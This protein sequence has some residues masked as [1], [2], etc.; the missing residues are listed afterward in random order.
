MRALFDY[1]VITSNRISSSLSSM[2]RT[3]SARAIQGGGNGSGFETPRAILRTEAK[4]FKQISKQI[5]HQ[6]SRKHSEML[7]T[8]NNGAKMNYEGKLIK[9]WMNELTERVFVLN[10]RKRESSGNTRTGEEKRSSDAGEEQE[11]TRGLVHCNMVL[12]NQGS[13]IN[14]CGQRGV[15]LKSI[16][17]QEQAYT[18]R[19]TTPDTENSN[20]RLSPKVLSSFSRI[21]PGL[22]KSTEEVVSLWRHGNAVQGVPA[23]RHFCSL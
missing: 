22:P 16:S 14:S 6:S 20:L 7:A 18:E 3:G 4:S 19:N 23:L 2:E 9:I 11:A 8:H 21:I 17:S 10:Q 13:C 12:H 15:A 1:S 5:L